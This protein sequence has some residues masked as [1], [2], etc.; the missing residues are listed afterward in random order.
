LLY[1]NS[2]SFVGEE[3]QLLAEEVRKALG[4][5]PIVLAHEQDPQLGGCPF[6]R[7][8]HTTPEDL[9][10]LGLYRFNRKATIE[11]QL[12]P[13]RS[14]S[15]ALVAKSLGAVPVGP[16]LTQMLRYSVRQSCRFVRETTHARKSRVQQPRVS[17]RHSPPRR[18][19]TQSDEQT[20]SR[21]SAAEQPS[22]RQS[23]AW[24]VSEPQPNAQQANERHLT[25]NVQASQRASQRHVSRRRSAG[26]TA[27]A[28][29]DR[30][31]HSSEREP[32]DRELAGEATEASETD[33]LDLVMRQST[34]RASV[35][36]QRTE[37]LRRAVSME[38]E[39]GATHEVPSPT[40]PP[41]T[42]AG[43]IGSA[44]AM[45]GLLAKGK[46]LGQACLS[47]RI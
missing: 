2:A 28:Q 44:L 4:T 16:L 47:D 11:C 35:A 8:L 12:P 13:L 40:P 46:P 36:R 19:M 37:R 29:S 18:S 43:S 26:Q 23:R 22:A 38:E 42:A 7:L 5:L 34:H 41:S 25:R 30:R 31:L 27:T 15:L 21:A 32:A 3:G 1:L 17:I 33:E 39:G 45:G 6:D 9:I 10:S 20:T 14:V 24:S